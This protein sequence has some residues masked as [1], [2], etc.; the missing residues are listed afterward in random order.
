MFYRFFAASLM[1]VSYE[2]ALESTYPIPESVSCSILNAWTFF[3]AIVSSFGTEL[4]LDVIDY[5]ITFVI[6]ALL[7]FCCSLG[8]FAISPRLRRYEANTV[9]VESSQNANT[10]EL[11]L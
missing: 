4:L 2:F 6:L 10:T 8:V 7:M 9:V 3:F 1:V 11:G 5:P